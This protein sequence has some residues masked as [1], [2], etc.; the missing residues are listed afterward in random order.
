MII[1]HALL[2]DGLERVIVLHGWFGDH[3]AFSPMF[4]Y[5]D[6]RTFTY[7]FIDY[8]GYGTSRD[9]GGEHSMKEISS[10]AIALADNL[11]WER[12][13]VIGHS[14]GGMAM[15]RVALDAKGRVKCGVAITPVPASGVPLDPEGQALFSGAAD[16]DDNRRAILDF[17][18]GGRNSRSW[19]DYKVKRSRETTTRDAFAGYLTAW[20]KTDFADEVKGLDLAVL[21]LAGE[22]DPAL[23][24][25]VMEQT[26]LAWLPKSKMSV[27]ANAGH[28][29]M[30]ET[31]VNL[32]TTMEA[33]MREHSGA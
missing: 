27:I 33:F 2:G 11:S 29:P 12:F 14:M 26:Y 5:L 3:T 32:A 4:P 23:T 17:T 7:A 25:A 31:P 22:H 24:P 1:G 20:T 28:Y 21:V 30:D 9:I 10:D 6:Q 13:H 18:T 16:S 15:Q 19:L 8:R